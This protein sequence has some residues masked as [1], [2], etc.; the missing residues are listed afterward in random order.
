[1]CIG[2]RLYV[3]DTHWYDDRYALEKKPKKIYGSESQENKEEEK[4]IEV[5]EASDQEDLH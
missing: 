1:M 2:D 3:S 4:S 5:K